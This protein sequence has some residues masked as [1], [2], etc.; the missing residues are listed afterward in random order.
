[1]RRNLSLRFWIETTVATLAGFLGLLTLTWHDWIE[2][3]FGVDPDRHNGSLEWILVVTLL[4]IA[5]ILAR[6][7]RTQWRRAT[8]PERT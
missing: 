8:L 5:L 3:V 6:A 1:M 2:G 4:A 7:A